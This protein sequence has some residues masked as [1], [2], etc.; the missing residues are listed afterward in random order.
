MFNLIIDQNGLNFDLP[1]MINR[2]NVL[3]HQYDKLNYYPLN[4]TFS[5]Q[6]SLKRVIKLKCPTK[7]GENTCGNVL[8]YSKKMLCYECNTIIDADQPSPNGFFLQ[9]YHTSSKN[10]FTCFGLSVHIDLQ[11]TSWKPNISL[12]D[13][14]K[15]RSL[16]ALSTYWLKSPIHFHFFIRDTI[17]LLSS[18]V[19][20]KDDGT[21]VLFSGIITLNDYHN[22]CMR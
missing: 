8:E 11:N 1:F 12:A 5:I 14:P 15:Q 6:S 10:K 9:D 4:W 19:N 20:Q 2:I 7:K 17:S 13:G 3:K 21:L 22:I 18:D 16:D